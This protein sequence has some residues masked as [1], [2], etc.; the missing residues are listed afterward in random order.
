MKERIQKLMAQAGLCSRRAAEEIIRA[1]GVTVNG[2]RAELGDSADPV[3]DKIVV[4]GK[5]LRR[6]E[7][8][9]DA[10]QAARLCFHAQG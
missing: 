10:E 9:L 7:S 6:R 2:R 4:N 5:P 3:R 8:V 1:G